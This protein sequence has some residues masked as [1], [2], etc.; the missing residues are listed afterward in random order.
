MVVINST[1]LIYL[2]KIGK[3]GRVVEHFGQVLI[4]KAVY[5]ETVHKGMALGKP[6]ASVINELVSDGRIKIEKVEKTLG[7]IRGLHTGEVE[8]LSLAKERSDELIVDDKAA[9]EYAK[10]LRIKVQR[11]VKLMLNLTRDKRLTLDDL[12]R[13]LLLLSQ[14]GFWLT[15]DIYARILEE[16]RTIS[17]PARNN[18]SSPFVHD[19]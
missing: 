13:N 18:T 17:D 14:S 5:E 12:E 8:A 9:Y 11:S 3:L 15:A 10:I 19:P 4:P 6:E 7:E 16:A 1:P 2:A